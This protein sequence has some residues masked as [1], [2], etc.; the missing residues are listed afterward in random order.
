MEGRGGFYFKDC[1]IS[2]SMLQLATSVNMLQYVSIV[3]V[4]HR[5]QTLLLIAQSLTPQSLSQVK[6]DIHLL[7]QVKAHCKHLI[8]FLM[9]F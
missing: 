5:G 2:V 1:L 6:V 9:G 7:P 3:T 8:P 4:G